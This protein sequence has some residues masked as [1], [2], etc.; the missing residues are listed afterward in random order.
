MLTSPGPAAIA[1]I[2]I[3]GPAV[4][5]FLERHV[6]TSRGLAAGAPASGEVVRGQLIEAAGAALDDILVSVHA[7]PP[8]WD[9]R[10]H[11]HGSPWLVRHCAALLRKSGFVQRDAATTTL[12]PSRDMLEAEA[13]A[14]LPRMLTLRGARWL[15]Q[16][17]SRLRTELNVLLDTTSL[18]TARG[19]C[20]TLAAGLAVVEWFSRP[21]RVALIGPPNAGKSTLA[22]ALADQTASLVSAVPGTTRDWVDV[23][24]QL[25]GF[26][27]LWLDTAGLRRSADLLEAESMARTRQVMQNA[28]AVVVVLDAAGE[29]AP[30]REA[31]IRAYGDME[32]ACVALNKADLPGCAKAVPE[33]VSASWEQRTVV[34]SAAERTGLE[35]LG[36]RLLNA[37]GREEAHVERPGAFT[38]RQAGL[39]EAGAAAPDRVRL[40]DAARACL[41]SP[42]GG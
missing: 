34:V 10:L 23:P 4:A 19:T 32:A 30:L 15:L 8:A 27:V 24:G 42:A 17:V 14:L 36:R 9:L 41:G 3:C 22:N 1:V 12:W 18:E 31:F 28:D 35:A 11:L 16:Q 40:S 37:L 21:A 26:P 38:E 5:G 29:A 7:H 20:R 33:S 13:W 25:H 2:R 39:L 6:R